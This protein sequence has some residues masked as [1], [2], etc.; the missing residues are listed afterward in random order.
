MVFVDSDF[1]GSFASMALRLL[2]CA[3]FTHFMHHRIVALTRFDQGKIDLFIAE[4]WPIKGRIVG[5]ERGLQPRFI[6][7]LRNSGL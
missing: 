7:A 2:R 5:C 3:A 4:P 1:T 6:I